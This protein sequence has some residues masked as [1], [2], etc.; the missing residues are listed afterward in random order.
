[1]SFT[2]EYY[3]I[4]ITNPFSLIREECFYKNEYNRYYW[5]DGT[6]MGY[7]KAKF[8]ELNNE[9]LTDEQVTIILDDLT[10]AECLGIY[11][12]FC[13]NMEAQASHIWT[14]IL[15]LNPY[16]D[17]LITIA[18]LCY[19]GAKDKFLHFFSYE[20]HPDVVKELVN[21]I[22]EQL[23]YEEFDTA[24]SEAKAI[25][26]LNILINNSQQFNYAKEFLL[27]FHSRFGIEHDEE[28]N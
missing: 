28:V 17:G 8:I 23:E 22:L 2:M 26:E 16:D 9:E 1:M 6:I 5:R 15:M 4:I 20:L 25:G 24:L 3:D 7:L 27:N 21:S 10:P 19:L 18:E 14:R 12:Y 11:I 13:K